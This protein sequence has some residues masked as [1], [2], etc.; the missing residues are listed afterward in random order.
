[1]R[2]PELLPALAISGER[3]NR[4]FS[5]LPANSTLARI[6]VM[7]PPDRKAYW[8][9]DRDET[10][11]VSTENTADRQPESDMHSPV[12]REAKRGSSDPS[13]LRAAI[14]EGRT[15][16]K[17]AHPD[18]AAAPLG[19]DDEAAGTPATPER[20]AIAARHEMRAPQPN[21]EQS[22][23]SRG[24]VFALVVAGAAALAIAVFS[25]AS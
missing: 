23:G 3:L 12:K 7:S 11:R 14:D 16:D 15:G 17:V 6:Q 10:S 21:E 22:A 4:C 24:L 19:T 9:F 5:A 2:N 8:R 25:M 13:V 18:P 20:V 1:M